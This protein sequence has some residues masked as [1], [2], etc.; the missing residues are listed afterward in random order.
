[1]YDPLYPEI[2]HS[3]F[4]KCNW[5][6]FYRDAKEVIPMNVPGPLGKEVDTYMIVDSA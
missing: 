1:M 4:K 2:D 3:V 5:S 6:E